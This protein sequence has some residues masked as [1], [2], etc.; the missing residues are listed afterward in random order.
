[1]THIFYLEQRLNNHFVCFY[2]P[3]LDLCLRV[4]PKHLFRKLGID[5]Q[6]ALKKIAKILSFKSFK[7]VY[8]WK[9]RTN[10]TLWKNKDYSCSL[11]RIF[12]LFL[13][14]KLGK[15]KTWTPLSFTISRCLE[16]AKA[17]RFMLCHLKTDTVSRKKTKL[18][19]FNGVNLSDLSFTYMSG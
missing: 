1:M 16:R 7:F 5:I 14:K 3:Y 15:L 4:S 13:E 6:A 2:N 10:C 12:I 19:G 17:Y 18:M 8:T 11:Y 9:F